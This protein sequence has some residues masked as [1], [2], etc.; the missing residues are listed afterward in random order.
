MTKLQAREALRA[1]VTKRTGQNLGGRVRKD[2]SVTFEWFV[3]NKRAEWAD[4]KSEVTAFE[5]RRY[6][7]SL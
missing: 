2:S 1:E 5:W 6:L 3:R 4:Y 7:T